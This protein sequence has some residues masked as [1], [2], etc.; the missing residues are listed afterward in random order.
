[1]LRVKE[2]KA[3]ARRTLSGRYVTVIAAYFI[4][5]AIKVLMWA[6]TGMSA[7]MTGLH[8]G[9]LGSMMGTGI[10]FSFPKL[11]C[12][13]MLTMFLLVVTVIVSLWFEIG[14]TKLMLNICRGLKGSVRDVFYGFR[15]GSNTLCF[16]LVGI[17][18]GFISFVIN[19]VQK[20]LYAL[21]GHVFANHTEAHIAA[22]IVI[23]LI[24]LFAMWYVA[25]AFM[26]AKII[27]ADKRESSIGG[28]LAASR[29]LM[30]GRKLKGFWLLYF[31]FLF[32]YILIFICGPAALWISPYIACTTIIFYMDADGTLWQLPGESD[33]PSDATQGGA[34]ANESV[35]QE[36]AAGSQESMQDSETANEV[37]I[38]QDTISEKTMQPDT[39]VQPDVPEHAT[40]AD[41][42]PDVTEYTATEDVQPDVTEHATTADVS[43]DVTE[44]AVT[45]DAQ[46]EEGKTPNCSAPSSDSAS[47][48]TQDV[49]TPKDTTENDAENVTENDTE[50]N[51]ENNTA[52][53]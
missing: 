8:A 48:D 6:I 30:K 28:A 24:T 39:A 38:Q 11:L 52:Y 47:I 36:T 51:T 40:T 45:A 33:A 19:V 16:I 15:E 23:T 1:M 53:Q 10:A 34:A 12:G 27:I 2:C 46:A 50:S 37:S 41:V 26:F 7:F 31:S 18:L 17:V 9:V 44:Q 14:S 5:I 32:W 43:P 49:S 4:T 42:Q 25:T 20:L 13:T 29:R 35:T 22:V 21:A 3:L